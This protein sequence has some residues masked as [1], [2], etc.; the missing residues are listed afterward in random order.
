MFLKKTKNIIDNFLNFRKRN[1]VILYPT[2]NFKQPAKYVLFSYLKSPLLWPDKSERFQGHSNKWESKAIAN[3]FNKLGYHVEAIDYNDR[4]FLPTRNYEIVFDIFENLGRWA[5]G[6]SESTIKLL[7]LTG[8]DPYYQNAAE[9]KRVAEV[10]RRRKGNY[11]PKRM[12][13]EPERTHISINAAN[14]CS[15]I[16]NEHTLRTYPKEFRHKIKLVTVSGS[17]IEKIEIRDSI[18]GKREFL[19][20][21]GGGAV[22]KGLD[23]V[24]EVFFNHPHLILHVVGNITSEEDFM[25]LYKKELLETPNIHFHGYLLPSSTKFKKILSNIF[26]FIAPS[27][28]EGKSP[29]VVTCLQLGLFPIISRD[30]GIDLPINC[31]FYI[32]KLRIA[33]I[34][35]HV[36]AVMEMNDEDIISQIKQTQVAALLAYSKEKFNSEMEEFII[37][38]LNEYL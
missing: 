18:P 4:T 7:H 29:A 5:P 2:D 19:W 22:H 15:L 23:L 27:C 17:E 8:S 1:S 28:S 25:A 26:C 11:S 24:L 12:I 10:K 3:I 37:K 38:A 13:A 35:K 21:F 32:E 33:D 31:G 16:G 6:L 14:A 36:F 20:F 34:E 9:R 30:T